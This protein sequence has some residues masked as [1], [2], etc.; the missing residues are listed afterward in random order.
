MPP[1]PA[2]G[3]V[4]PPAKTTGDEPTPA[5]AQATSS[6]EGAEL[7]DESAT[8]RFPSLNAEIA[9][10]DGPSEDVGSRSLPIAVPRPMVPPP[11]SVGSASSSSGLR[12]PSLGPPT[13]AGSAADSAG[14]W[15]KTDGW[16][17][18][19]D[20]G[21]GSVPTGAGAPKAMPRP[22]PTA[23]KPT[24]V[25]RVGALPKVMPA[26]KTTPT[27][28][29]TRA[30]DA[31]AS[32]G[33]SSD[34][35]PLFGAAQSPAGSPSLGAGPLF[36]EARSPGAAQSLDGS[37]SLGAAHSPDGS[38]LDV[39]YLLDGSPSL[40]TAP[41]SHPEPAWDTPLLDAAPSLDGEASPDGVP[42]LDSASLLGA[43]IALETTPEEP[44]QDAAPSVP[45]LPLP[46][47]MRDGPAPRAA[48]FRANPRPPRT[49]TPGAMAP[50]RGMMPP[51]LR[52]DEEPRLKPG[53]TA[54]F[55]AQVAVEL[56]EEVDRSRAAA[57][58]PIASEPAVDLLARD[59][60][61]DAVP[62]VAPRAAVA[63][64]T[65]PKAVAAAVAYGSERDAQ[66]KRRGMI[67]GVVGV[68]AAIGLVV[69]LSMGKDDEPA[70]QTAAAT[71]AVEPTPPTPAADDGKVI[72]EVVPPAPSP[73]V[74]VVEDEAGSTGEPAAAETGATSDDEPAM[75][76]STGPQ[77]EPA[78][79]D[80]ATEPAA[81][82]SSRKPSSSKSK[83]SSKPTA[84]DEPKPKA[85][86]KPDDGAPSAQKLLKQARTA[87]NAGK[88]STAYSLASKSNRMEP[89]GDA[90]EVMALAACQMNDV[91]KAKSALRNV[92]LFRRS[93]VRSTCKTKHNV[94]IPL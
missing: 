28:K 77:E 70:P 91:D 39:A 54:A 89:T 74:A 59:E 4:R 34:A 85:E 22:K 67:L 18:D 94:K 11:P 61:E 92:T 8:A 1:P 3:S 64:S 36:G 38:S 25:P 21:S 69:W 76:A 13:A 88:G 75:A 80:A 55:V 83:S 56:M 15:P 81:S 6:G 78:P 17:L 52:D 48:D 33:A 72:A 5:E 20:A 26:P 79:V 30:V 23:P 65:A 16:D 58:E 42:M 82:S 68:A 87:Y 41:S 86:P 66:A 51:K 63:A 43:A 93:S 62:L 10:D 7:G 84:Q 50:L 73:L 35:G 24:S 19:D 90:A 32:A 14:S 46:G 31:T 47:M 27:P 37:S 57:R 49:Q 71:V 12:A 44:N 53:D 40:G 29:A 45:R 9:E 60:H 2:I